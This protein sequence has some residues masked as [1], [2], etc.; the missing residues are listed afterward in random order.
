MTLTFEPLGADEIASAAADKPLLSG[1]NAV[2]E[3]RAT[4][5]IV[6]NDA[7]STYPATDES[8]PDGPASLLGDGRL[9]LQT[10]PDAADTNFYLH[11]YHPAGF[12]ADTIVFANHN[13]GTINATLEIRFSANGDHTGNTAQVLATTPAFTTDNRYT[14]LKLGVSEDNRYR[15]IT[16]VRIRIRPTPAAVPRIGELWLGLRAQLDHQPDEPWAYSTLGY[17]VDRWQTK[18]GGQ[19]NYIRH[20]GQRLFSARLVSG[21]STIESRLQAWR[22]GCS[23]GAQPFLWIDKPE[24]EPEAAYWMNATSPITGNTEGPVARVYG[25][26]AAEVYPYV[27]T[28]N[29]E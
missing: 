14:A 2:T 22:A 11:I 26:S 19:V 27:A 4:G 1:L 3:A 28:E 10:F 9:D 24:S 25:V 23:H 6:W 5:D 13:F 7:D 17:N 18:N 12:D 21:T 8:D 16:H 29:D 20:H 15:G